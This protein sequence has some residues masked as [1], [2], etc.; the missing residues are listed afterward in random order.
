MQNYSACKDLNF[1]KG[2]A[3]RSG[4]GS[5]Q[6]YIIMLCTEIEYSWVTMFKST[7][8]CCVL[9]L[10]TAG[11]PCLKVHYHVVC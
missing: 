6:E 5:V 9:R 3:V 10:N 1:E 7:L 4:W 11:L 2:A 8:S